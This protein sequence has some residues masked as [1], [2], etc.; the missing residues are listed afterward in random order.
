MALAQAE[1]VRALLTRT[2]PF[3]TVEVIPVTTRA[4][5]W[6]GDL[7]ALGGKGH[8]V[9]QLDQMLTT[10]AVD[11]VAHCVKDMES[12]RAVPGGL[13]IAAFL[14]RDDARDVLVQP[15]QPPVDLN[16]PVPADVLATLPTGARVGTSAVR[17]RA[18]LHV[19][20]PD[21]ELLASRG[22]VNSRLARL[23]SG[24]W[25]ALVLAAAGL[26]RIGRADAVT[27]VLPPDQFPPAAGAGIIA[28]T[29]RD[30][31][32]QTWDLLRR[33]DHARTRAAALA[34]R[35]CLATLQG[36]C[37][38]PIAAHAT[39]VRGKLVLR[40]AVYAVDGTA[41][42]ASHGIGSPLDPS[43]LGDDVA[44]DLI[45]QGARDLITAA[46]HQETVAAST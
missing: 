24:E 34:E 28:V 10:G 11:A 41:V 42:I 8:F 4:D 17:R 25:D 15:G 5:Q 36:H 38:S 45:E 23:A 13:T 16:G 30:R 18:Q 39:H 46:A 14:E 6:T 43:T 44:V 9:R 7:A 27:A 33:L 3:L 29:C 21:L 19:A 22:N 35:A 32:Q 26:E 37:N 20:R 31:D 2:N 40:A 1:R 12:D